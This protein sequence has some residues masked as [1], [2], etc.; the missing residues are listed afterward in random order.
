MT[1]RKGL[2]WLAAWAAAALATAGT[3]SFESYHDPNTQDQ[4]YCAECHTGFIDRGPLHQRHR[5]WVFNCDH[6]HTGTGRDNPLLVWA[7]DD[8][9]DRWGCAG[10]HGRDYGETIAQDYRGFPTAGK[11]KS[12][13]YALRM[14]H[15]ERGQGD[16]IS[17]H[18]DN[19]AILPEDIEP[20]YYGDPKIF[21][22]DSCTDVVDN[23]RDGFMDAADVDCGAAGTIGEPDMLLVTAYDASAGSM[24]LSYAPACST[25]DHFIEWGLL[26]DVATYTYS[27]RQ[28]SIGV[29]GNYTWLYPQGSIFFIIVAEDG[30]VEGS[31][32][33]DSGGQERPE[34]TTTPLCQVPQDLTQPCL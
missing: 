29:S 23:D 12:S 30:I 20:P 7:N 17:C 10:C 14:S 11:A 9:I 22:T 16:C 21:F 28:C 8:G 4:G 13:G 27:D 31:Y 25:N 24:D 15:N 32:G 26:T 2:W 6:C 19:V 5:D 33:R 3:L 1:N 18:N 34:D